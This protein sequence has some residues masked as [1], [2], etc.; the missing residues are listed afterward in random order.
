MEKVGRNDPC[1]CGSGKK[2]KKCCESK[3]QKKSIGS[4][5][6]LSGTNKM[7]S[8]FQRHVTPISSPKPPEIPPAEPVQ[9]VPAGATL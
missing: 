1:P 7:S 5:Q 2:F 6:I 4:A 9:E 8:F 3:T